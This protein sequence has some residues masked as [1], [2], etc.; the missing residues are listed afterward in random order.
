MRRGSLQLRLSLG[1]AAVI[2]V[3]L[4]VAGAGLTYL[5][6][7]HVTRRLESELIDHLR[8]IAASVLIDEAGRIG[9]STRPADPEFEAPLSGL[10]WQVSDESGPALL[11]SASLWDAEIQLPNDLLLDGAVHRHQL[12]GPDKSN[13]IAVERRLG[14]DRTDG[15]VQ[16]LRLIVAVDKR[17]VTNARADF[18]SDLTI[19]LAGLAAV[20]M[21][22]GWLQ[23]RIGLSPLANLGGRI[24]EIRSGSA[25]RLQRDVPDEI[26]PLV[27]EINALLDHGDETLERSRRRAADLAHGLKTPLTALAGDAR[28]LRE[29]GET[30]IADDLE[31]AA[32]GMRRHVDHELARARIG[33]AMAHGAQANVKEAV[34]AV[35]RTLRRTPAAGEKAFE[36]NIL[37]AL[38]VAMDR[39]DLIELL[40]NIL[41]NAVRHARTKVRI[42]A[43]AVS[44][45]TGTAVTVAD[46]GPGI[47]QS[48]RDKVLRAGYRLDETM[49]G[50]GLGLSIASDIVDAY[51]GAIDLSKSDIGGLQV[52]LRIPPV[53]VHLA[54]G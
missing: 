5:F 3:A 31:S 13:L 30:E 39:A 34:D 22:A 43:E 25:K 53:G 17:V 49:S 9:I 26:V 8:A 32:A 7:R 19:A 14:L 20:L 37:P 21:V 33:F 51:G 41:D 23:L 24:A 15:T 2:L 44:P 50:S 18:I 36:L 46:D 16:W 6:E 40:G 27:D 4:V 12:A 52:D 47:P 54:Q 38:T 29:R 10:Y 48:D 11:R 1:G 35:L 42:S 45:T 28:R